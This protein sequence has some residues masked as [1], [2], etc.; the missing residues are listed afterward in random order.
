LP[1]WVGQAVAWIL[2]VAGVSMLLG[3]QI[4]FLGTGFLNGVWMIFIGWFL[5]NAAAQSHRKILVH[6]ILEDV[7]VKKMMHT[8]VP[9]VPA[10]M[11][12]ETLINNHLMGSNDQAFMVSDDEKTVGMV[13]IDDIHKLPPE[14]CQTTLVREIMTPSKQLIGVAPEENAS[15]ALDRF[16]NQNV[17]QLPVVI[18]NKIVGLLDRHDIVR[19]LELQSHAG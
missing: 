16:Q 18:G 15:D 9:V 1:S 12:A 11:T 7:P 14:S 4:P 8:N 2:I 10:N 3:R 5:Q 6:D 17:H 19:W 13:T